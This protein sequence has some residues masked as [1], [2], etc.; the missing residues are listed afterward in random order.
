VVVVNVVQLIE[1]MYSEAL[2]S[3]LVNFTYSQDFMRRLASFYKKSIMGSTMKLG[4][5]HIAHEE[6]SASHIE[7]NVVMQLD[8][9]SADIIF[10]ASRDGVLRN[11][12][13]LINSALNYA[14]SSSVL[15]G[16]ET[17]E[18]LDILALGVG[19]H[20]SSS[21]MKLLLDREC[22]DFLV[23]ISGVHCVVFE[24]Q[25][26]I[27]ILN[28]I[29][30][31]GAMLSGSV[32]SKNQFFTSD[33]VFHLCGGPNKDNMT[34]EKLQDG[35]RRC[36]VSASIGTCYSIRFEFTEVYVGDYGMHNCLSEFSQH[37]K[38]QISMF[39]HDDFQLVKC[40]IQVHHPF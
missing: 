19:F 14:S 2:K 1:S 3:A 18:L 29:K 32:L 35:S 33:C 9:G 23:S 22:T 34:H 28:G 27:S 24:N 38:Q 17:Q 16:M 36:C 40:N 11:P 6:T 5:D 37:S 25:A 39:I 21:S 10:S 4:V 30:N 13:I 12:D 15:E 26:Q 7:L 31:D 20:I 8:L